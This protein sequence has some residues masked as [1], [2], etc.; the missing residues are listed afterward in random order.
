MSSEN[1]TVSKK[2]CGRTRPIISGPTESILVVFSR[3]AEARRFGGAEP[4]SPVG[5]Q[6]ANGRSKIEL[7]GVSDL[8]YLVVS[9]DVRRECACKQR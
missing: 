5:A 8:R 6:R 4:D 1:T 3:T 9:I 2:A 7:R